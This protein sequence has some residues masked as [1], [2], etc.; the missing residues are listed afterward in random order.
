MAESRRLP[1]RILLLISLIL[2]INLPNHLWELFSPQ[3]STAEV[4]YPMAENAENYYAIVQNSGLVTNIKENW[5]SWPIKLTYQLESGRL[6]MT[7]GYFLLGLYAGRSHLFISLENHIDKFST[8]NNTTKN[9]ILVLLL[10]GLLMYL[11]DLVTLPDITVVPEL[12]WAASFLFSIYNACLAIFYITGISLL[13][14]RRKFKNFLKP[15]AAMGR[16]AL[17]NYLLQ[18]VFGL[19]IFY[20]FGF[21]LFDQTSPA[22]NVLLAVLVF[23]IHLK[24]SQYWLKHFKQG[25]VEWLWKSITYFRIFPNKRRRKESVVS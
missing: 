13:F 8:W 9:A 16:M 4:I 21:R 24:L 1:L 7:F 6:L 23:Y 2:I 19:L 14:R 25:P 5:N 10:M 20:R 22:L 15:L 17:T 12:K 18:T 11:F 3:T